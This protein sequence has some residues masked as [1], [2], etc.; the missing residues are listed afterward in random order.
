MVQLLKELSFWNLL[1]KIES[2]TV[3]LMFLYS[4]VSTLNPIVG[5]VV[6]TSPNFNLYRI[7]VFPAASKP[8]INI[9]L[10]AFG[11]FTYTFANL[12]F[13][14]ETK[15]VKLYDAFFET[16][17]WHSLAMWLVSVSFY[18]ASNNVGTKMF[19]PF[20]ITLCIVFAF[21]VCIPI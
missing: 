17:A 13:Y 16:L 12:A 1:A 19:L 4:T 11:V 14:F 15:G 7:V 8:T 3:N 6:T 10:G 5:M 2:R 21:F 9:R 20:G 18:T